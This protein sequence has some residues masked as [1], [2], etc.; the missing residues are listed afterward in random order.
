MAGEMTVARVGGRLLGWS[1]RHRGIGTTGGKLC[2]GLPE[3][4]IP[5]AI[6]R[7][8]RRVT[9]PGDECKPSSL[10]RL[11]IDARTNRTKGAPAA[12]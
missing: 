8:P 5:V 4:E 9:Y 2:P 11:D 10:R 7:T 12:P 3:R 1:C 6:P